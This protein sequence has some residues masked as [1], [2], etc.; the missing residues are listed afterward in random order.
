V[1]TFVVECPPI[2]AKRFASRISLNSFMV[3]EINTASE[4][5][6]HTRNALR[7]AGWKVF[8]QSNLFDTNS[9]NLFLERRTEDPEGRLSHGFIV[10]D[11]GARTHIQL[12]EAVFDPEPPFQ[13]T[14]RPAVKSSTSVLK[15]SVCQ[16][17][18]CKLDGQP[19]TK[20]CSC[21]CHVDGAK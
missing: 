2:F 14:E 9:A 11:G 16:S 5:W 8:I 12:P 19:L 1:T 6:A 10:H 15:A 18:G 7:E 3:I 4:V 17:C 20:P 13:I 21:R